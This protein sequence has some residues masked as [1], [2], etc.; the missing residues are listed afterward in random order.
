MRPVSSTFLVAYC[1]GSVETRRKG[2]GGRGFGSRSS[3]GD[4]I[5][6]KLVMVDK[7]IKVEKSSLD[8]W[9]C[10]MSVDGCIMWNPFPPITSCG[11]LFIVGEEDECCI[12]REIG[13]GGSSN[14]YAELAHN[15]FMC[16]S[17]NGGADA[18]NDEA[19]ATDGAGLLAD[20][21][22]TLSISKGSTNGIE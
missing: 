10:R 5:V 6:S 2:H 22:P 9:F 8:Q 4:A 7:F 20:F 13:G 16:R 1:L 19:Q 11:E 21:M 14:G 3:L 15:D 17:V 12:E 18:L